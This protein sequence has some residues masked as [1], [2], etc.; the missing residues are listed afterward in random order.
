MKLSILTAV[1]LLAAGPVA[2][3]A[4]AQ[5]GTT[6]E[7]RKSDAQ[8]S[9]EIATR[10][11]NNKTLSPDAVK[12]KVEKG[13]VTLSGVVAKDADKATAEE[14]ARVPGVVRVENNLKSREKATDTVE[15]TAGTVVDKTKAGA[16]KTADV[17]KAGARKTVE[18]TKKVAGVTKK[19]AVK[20]GEN[21]TDGW[22]TSR[23]KTKF[24]G[25]EVLRASSINV[26][27]NNH[28]VTLKGAVPTTAAR[29]KAIELAKEV[30]GVDKV[31]DSLTI[32]DKI[33]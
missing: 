9:S 31:V 29:E 19:A 14:L 30:E 5:T 15:G 24:M 7:V 18:A 23:I 10:L 26:D 2:H 27:T 20:T 6:T 21:V 12:V 28:V 11:A 3:T 17:T 1:A 25:E 8:L 13:V 22:I 33:K 32:T 16:E 4:A